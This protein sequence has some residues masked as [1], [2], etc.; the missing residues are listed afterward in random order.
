MLKKTKEQSPLGKFKDFYFSDLGRTKLVDL[1][2]S[3]IYEIVKNSICGDKKRIELK[4]LF[5]FY[6]NQFVI[7]NYDT[8]VSE[9]NPVK[10]MDDFLLLGYFYLNRNLKLYKNLVEVIED[11]DFDK[12]K[13]KPELDKLSTF[14]IDNYLTPEVSKL[15]L[16]FYGK[17]QVH[18]EIG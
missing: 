3:T 9:L 7:C 5:S 1:L 16:E 18:L 4:F 12:L 14:I 6:S 15:I 10:K 2:N 13:M 11:F 17:N 8:N